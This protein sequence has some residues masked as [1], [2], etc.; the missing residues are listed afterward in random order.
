VFFYKPL[1]VVSK[2]SSLN[3][4]LV[5]YSEIALKSSP[6]RR[7]MENQLIAHIR[8]MLNR[9][10]LSGAGVNRDQ[11]RI[12]IRN[13]EPVKAALTASRVFGVASTMPAIETSVDL[14]DVV[15]AAAMF[16]T[17]TIKPNQTF[18]IDARRVGEHPYTSRDVEVK[19]GAEVLRMLS[20]KRVSVNLENPDKTIRIEARSR[21]AYIYSQVY[22]GP[23]GLPFGSQGKLVSLFSGGID[24][25][26]ASWLMMRRGAYVIPLFL[27]QRPFVGD[28][29]YGRAVKVVRKLREHVPIKEYHLYVI[30][31]GN[32]MKRIAEKV[33]KKFTCIICKRMMYQI[34]CSFAEPRGAQGVVTGESLGQV[35]SQ[36]LVNL[37][38]LEEAATMPIYRPLIG[39]NKLD[40]VRIA[41]KIG[42]YSSSIAP[43][44]GCSVVPKKPA[45][46]AKIDDV[47]E[48]EKRI[49]VKELVSNSFGMLSKLTL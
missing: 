6:V 41:R 16:A 30:P 37:K 10:G 29:Y 33:P 3:V 48:A 23:G 39:L 20:N 47:K 1:R 8:N 17:R 11:G 35:A 19:V 49:C 5:S 46:M 15:E 25:P 31:I 42:T 12:V 18:A 7:R 43:V 2:L 26:V 40:S 44:H 32:V 13:A 38:V 24:S 21:N 28:D 22:H 4:A 9:A 14:K 34:A 45:T 36:T 27:D